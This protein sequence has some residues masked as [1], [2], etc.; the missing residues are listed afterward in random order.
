MLHYYTVFAHVLLAKS[1]S[2]WIA[3]IC[4]QGHQ[5]RA[6]RARAK[7]ELAFSKSATI[8]W[9]N[10]LVMICNCI[11]DINF[12]F[13]CEQNFLQNIILRLQIH[14]L[15]YEISRGVARISVRGR[16]LIII[17]STKSLKNFRKIYIKFTYK[18]KIFSKILKNF[19][20]ILILDIFQKFSI[21]CVNI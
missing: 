15:V 9:L 3:S 4:G 13:I 1:K 11:L 5:A 12:V 6:T 14:V 21:N 18:F 19:S 8:K 16:H 7:D 17:Y 2:V 20:K 10:R